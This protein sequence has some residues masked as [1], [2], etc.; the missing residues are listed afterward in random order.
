MPLAVEIVN[1]E[2]SMLKNRLHL[3]F[4]YSI[5]RDKRRHFPHLCPPNPSETPLPLAVAHTGSTTAHRSAHSS[6]LL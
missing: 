2:S 4:K 1:G 3:G 6:P 5:G